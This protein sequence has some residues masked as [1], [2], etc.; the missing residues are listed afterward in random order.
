MNEKQLTKKKEYKVPFIVAYFKLN[1]LK[2]RNFGIFFLKMP[3]IRCYGYIVLFERCLKD[4]MPSLT[5]EDVFF[6]QTR[7]QLNKRNVEIYRIFLEKNFIIAIDI[8]HLFEFHKLGRIIHA[9][10]RGDPR[11]RTDGSQLNTC[12]IGHGPKTHTVHSD[13]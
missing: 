4:K 9:S 10:M 7:K 5:Q 8:L 11:A 1:F 2:Q 6:L 3:I 12:S 13:E